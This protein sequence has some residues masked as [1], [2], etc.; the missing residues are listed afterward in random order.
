MKRIGQ[1]GKYRDGIDEEYLEDVSS[2]IGQTDGIAGDGLQP[3]QG[4]CHQAQCR[5]VD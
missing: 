1:N 4:Y 5:D 3:V 2:V